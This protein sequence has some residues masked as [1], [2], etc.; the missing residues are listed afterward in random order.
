M[1]VK[2]AMDV[3]SNVVASEM[4]KNDN[5]R[6]VETQ[7]FLKKCDQLWKVFNDSNRLSDADHERLD[8]LEE[9]IQY[10]GEWKLQLQDEYETKSERAKHFI[11]CQTHFD[12]QVSIFM[13]QYLKIERTSPPAS[14]AEGI[15]E[16]PTVNVTSYTGP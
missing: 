2:Y 7:V 13:S 5:V 4:Q 11:T 9:V 3:L 15:F 1:K 8:K 6:T 10:F 16:S 12:I 14:F